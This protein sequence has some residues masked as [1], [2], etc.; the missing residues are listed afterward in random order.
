MR[1]LRGAAGLEADA[2]R[3]QSL[4]AGVAALLEDLHAR[5]ARDV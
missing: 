5:L 2:T 3:R 1:T 4:G